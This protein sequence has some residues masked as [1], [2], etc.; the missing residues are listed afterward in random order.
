MLT[1][2]AETPDLIQV[3]ENE[4]LHWFIAAKKVKFVTAKTFKEFS[5]NSKHGQLPAVMRLLAEV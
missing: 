3:S 1:Q 4:K 2:S 5:G